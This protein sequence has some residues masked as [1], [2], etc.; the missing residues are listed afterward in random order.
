MA[1]AA[2]QAEETDTVLDEMTELW[3]FRHLLRMLVRR[4]LKIRYKNSVLGFLWSIVPPVLQ[5]LVFSFMAQNAFG[6]KVP[7]YS[8]YL[9]AGMLPWGFFNNAILDA[10]G[11][12]LTSYN[13]IRKVYLPR[14]A[15]PLA[16]VISNFI[17]FLLAWAVYYVFFLGIARL[18]G[19]GIPF[20]PAMLLFPLVTLELLLLV[21][22]ISFIASALNVFHEDVKFLLQTLFGLALFVVPVF[23]PVDVIYYSRTMQRHPWLF[24]LYMLNPVTT[25]LNA[26]RSISL[27]PLVPAQINGHLAG[28]PALPFDWP[29]YLAGYAISILIAY[30]GYVYFNRR[31][32]QFVE[33]P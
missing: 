27:Q 28:K 5:V 26:Y 12:L 15:I 8:A 16:N 22:G 10:S 31:K 14:E 18:F 21:I 7:H 13:I 19:G 2:L 11:S 4:E 17:H 30:F 20:Q 25:I 29:S 32:W 6:V 3:R 9:L 33:R 1:T 24:H 23:Y